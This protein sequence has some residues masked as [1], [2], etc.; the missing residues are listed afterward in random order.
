MQRSV[1]HLFCNGEQID[2]YYFHG[3]SIL[4]SLEATTVAYNHNRTKRA[5]V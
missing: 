1:L 5:T 3:T 2:H 4:Y